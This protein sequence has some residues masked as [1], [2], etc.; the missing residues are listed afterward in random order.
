MT[1]SSESDW[2]GKL[3]MRGA[4]SAKGTGK[5]SR[6]RWFE[7]NPEGLSALDREGSEA[8]GSSVVERGY[9]IETSLLWSGRVSTNM[10]G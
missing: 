4:S 7:S 2:A 9:E 6:D 8:S 3:R 5:T 1:L 10:T